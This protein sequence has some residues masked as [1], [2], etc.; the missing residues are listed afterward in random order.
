MYPTK[1]T[2]TVD[3]S[4]ASSVHLPSMSVIADFCPALTTAPGSGELSAASTTV[5]LY[6]ALNWAEHPTK[7]RIRRDAM[8]CCRLFIVS[9]FI[10]KV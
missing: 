5:P 8:K 4:L 6:C 10:D 1:E 2:V 7:S 9:C 3:P